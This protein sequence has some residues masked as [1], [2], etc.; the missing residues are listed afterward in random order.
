MQGKMTR[1]ALSNINLVRVTA[2]QKNTRKHG[3]DVKENTRKRGK[4]QN[5]VTGK[6][7]ENNK[8]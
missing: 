2:V 1:P 7:T 6:N 4:L 3:L 5:S 8:K